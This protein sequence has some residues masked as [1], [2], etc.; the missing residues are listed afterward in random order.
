M[1]EK[2]KVLVTGLIFLCLLIVGGGLYYFLVLDRFHE[3]AKAQA[4]DV[5]SGPADESA[6]EGGAEERSPVALDDSDA[7]VRANIQGL[8]SQAAFAAWLKVGGL[9]RRFVAAVDNVANGVSP[10]P[11]LEFLEP[12]A[13]FKTVKKGRQLLIDPASYKRYDTVADVFSSLDTAM[14]VKAY[15]SL[16]PLIRDA[17]RELGYPT[18]DFQDT[19]VRAMD[20][21][22]Q[23]PLVRGSIAV[24]KQVLTYVIADRSLEELSPPQKHLLRMGPENVEIIQSKIREFA[25][26]LGVPP[27]RLPKSRTYTPR[28]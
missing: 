12:D 6:A 26:A 9:V 18:Q 4:A 5:V 25:T 8:S 3:P 20:E 14:S 2:R 17:Y 15:R 22:L 19:L 23:V 16:R 13:E 10:R 27:D 11:H 21:L 1:D 7:Y 28:S 24:E